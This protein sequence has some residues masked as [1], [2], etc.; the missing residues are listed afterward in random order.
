MT[1]IYLSDQ[2]RAKSDMN[3]FSLVDSVSVAAF[4]YLIHET[5]D[6]FYACL[7]RVLKKAS[8]LRIS[9]TSRFLIGY[10][11]GR[12]WDTE[13]MCLST[14]DTSHRTYLQF[15]LNDGTDDCFFLALDSS[16]LGFHQKSLPN[17][18]L[19]KINETCLL[20]KLTS[21]V[22]QKHELKRKQ[23]ETPL[24]M[25]HKQRK[26]RRG[27]TKSLNDFPA[28]KNVE[29]ALS[30]SAI[31]EIINS[32]CKDKNEYEFADFLKGLF[33]ASNIFK[34]VQVGGY[35]GNVVK[36]AN[37]QGLTIFFIVTH[38][39]YMS[40]QTDKM[41][42][43]NDNI[44]NQ[45]YLK[46][47]I[48]CD[49]SLVSILIAELE[50]NIRNDQCSLFNLKSSSFIEQ[51]RKYCNTPKYSMN[52]VNKDSL[53]SCDYETSKQSLNCENFKNLIDIVEEARIGTENHSNE[54]FKMT[55]N[56]YRS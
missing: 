51:L 10:L 4:E 23:V 1:R 22:E 52:N 3:I 41:S 9:S 31:I 55:K 37:R 7:T 49:S 50:I 47:H 36:I 24:L 29:L 17:K 25:A 40:S 18:K 42:L 21:S 5:V 54:G 20:I 33:S 48:D 46:D 16:L 34:V 43:S 15:K 56:V 12:G 39:S 38:S 8:L 27:K 44:L 14:I 19:S 28:R 35:F 45:E 6:H 30:L 2:K 32:S 11:I 53:P 13:N 26:V